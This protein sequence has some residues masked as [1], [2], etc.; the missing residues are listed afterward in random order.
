MKPSIEQEQRAAEL[1][2]RVAELAGL[3]CGPDTFGV[4]GELRDWG[5]EV[6]RFGF[7]DLR[8][9]AAVVINLPEQL[10][11]AGEQAAASHVP[12][13]KPQLPACLAPSGILEF[14]EAVVTVAGPSGAA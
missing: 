4:R 2:P 14:Y 1:A 5:R 11:L 8:A 12:M 13:T 3:Y 9:F 6:H 10:Q 7:L